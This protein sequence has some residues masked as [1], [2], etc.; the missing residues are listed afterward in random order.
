K[1]DTQVYI[2]DTIGELGL[3]YRLAS[4]AFIGGSL[5]PHGGQNPLEP[6]RLGC[7]VI[8]GPHT[9]NFRQPYD[10]ILSAQGTGRVS[11]ATDIAAMAKRLLTNPEE[12]KALG[13]SAQAA[14]VAL[15]GAVEKTIVAIEALLDARP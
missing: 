1:M 8:T 15:G 6:A 5:I 12:T 9:E 2:A 4:F 3:F 10:A 13:K 14:A 7:A 11:S